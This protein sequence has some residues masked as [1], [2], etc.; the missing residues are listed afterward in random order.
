MWHTKRAAPKTQVT[1]V[2]I[3]GYWLGPNF[4]LWSD[5]LKQKPHGSWGKFRTT[6]PGANIVCKVTERKPLPN[7]KSPSHQVLAV[8]AAR[9]AQSQADLRRNLEGTQ[10]KSNTLGNLNQLK[11]LQHFWSLWVNHRTGHGFQLTSNIRI[12]WFHPAV[13]LTLPPLYEKREA[14]WS[15]SSLVGSFRSFPK[16]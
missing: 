10:K 15:W 4:S 3:K 5:P 12:W 8:S 14:T 6:I 9:G 2:T 16:S 1:Q 13:I 7:A 11:S